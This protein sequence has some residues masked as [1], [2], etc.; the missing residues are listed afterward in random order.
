VVKKTVW[1]KGYSL[2]LEGS[3]EDA[4]KQL[5]D[6]AAKYPGAK[7][8]EFEEQ[9]SNSDRRYLYLMTERLETDQEEQAREANETR[10]ANEHE[11]RER[12]Q[13][14]ALQKKYGGGQ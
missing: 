12:A 13:L 1:V 7:L 11:Q 5:A 10:W 9:Y 8:E 4:A 2:D 3:I 14:A 6:L